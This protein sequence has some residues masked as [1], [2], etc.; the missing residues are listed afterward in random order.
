MLQKPF[1]H[2]KV[3]TAGNSKEYGPL[4]QTFLAFHCAC[5]DVSEEPA[6]S[7][8]STAVFLVYNEQTEILMKPSCV[9][10]SMRVYISYSGSGSSVGIASD[11]GLDGL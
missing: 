1:L 10:M 3:L 6:A 2:F 11:S 4:D 5:I 8:F 7:L 9:C